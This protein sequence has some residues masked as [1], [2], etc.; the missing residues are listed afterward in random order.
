MPWLLLH[1]EAHWS[2][3]VG[4]TP[5]LLSALVAFVHTYTTQPWDVQQK[6]LWSS[7]GSV[8]VQ[9]LCFLQ[10]RVLR[11]VRSKYQFYL[12]VNSSL[13]GAYTTSSW[14]RNIVVV[15]GWG[16]VST[17]MGEACFLPLRSAILSWITDVSTHP[18]CNSHFHIHN[19]TR[20]TLGCLDTYPNVRIQYINQQS[21][22]G[23][24][25]M[26]VTQTLCLVQMDAH[27]L[28]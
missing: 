7:P 10:H 2:V 3:E 14:P 9:F 17:T 18:V 16:S 5:A 11:L 4:I 6:Y 12:Q 25:S 24:N 28:A 21:L 23:A 27:R 13:R 26:V 22:Y 20:C 19:P 15:C 8:C 1:S